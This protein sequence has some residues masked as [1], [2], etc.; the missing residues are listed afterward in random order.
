M[1]AMAA[2]LLCH[3]GC[4]EPA[5]DQI[6]HG[7]ANDG[8]VIQECWGRDV[9]A[10]SLCNMKSLHSFRDS[11]YSIAAISDSNSDKEPD[12]VARPRYRASYVGHQCEL[13]YQI[14]MWCDGTST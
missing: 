6:R 3:Y 5:I 8:T 9:W 2:L 7:S 13:N 4:S 14:A 12:C 1:A 11:F 10:L